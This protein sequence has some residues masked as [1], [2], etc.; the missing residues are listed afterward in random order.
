[1]LRLENGAVRVRTRN[2]SACSLASGHLW[3][4]ARRRLKPPSIRGMSCAG[5]GCRRRA[6]RS[7]RTGWSRLPGRRT[8][9]TDKKTSCA[10]RASTAQTPAESAAAPRPPH[11][12]PCRARPPTHSG[13]PFSGR[14]S[15]STVRIHRTSAPSL[16]EAVRLCK[17]STRCDPTAPR[18]TP[19]VSDHETSAQ[20]RRGLR[21]RAG[22]SACALCLTVRRC[23]C[24]CHAQ[25]RTEYI[26]DVA[27]HVTRDAGCP[28]VLI[29]KPF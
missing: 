23:C 4:R 7:T 10:R 20:S 29:I 8:P 26:G 12:P 5:R 28:W 16:K 27:G 1:M 18:T 14:T 3:T 21:I 13:A 6:D 24:R 9:R 25:G 17:A 15:R 2:S 11:H 19:V 22:R